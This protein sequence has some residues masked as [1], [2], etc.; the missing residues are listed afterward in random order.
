MRELSSGIDTR[1]KLKDVLL[2][3]HLSIVARRPVF[4]AS[5]WTRLIMSYPS[6][7]LAIQEQVPRFILTLV[8]T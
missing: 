1:F 8:Y 6:D 5:S 3:L 2:R 7:F 4:S